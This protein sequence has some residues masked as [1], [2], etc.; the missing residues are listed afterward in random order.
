MSTQQS[1]TAIVIDK[2]KAI[3]FPVLLCIVGFFMNRALDDLESVKQKLS[4]IQQHEIHIDDKQLD[5]E[6]EYARIDNTLIDHGNR[7]TK[8][9]K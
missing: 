3:A 9:E 2:I 5:I 4:D 1:S 7:I 6:S 8:L